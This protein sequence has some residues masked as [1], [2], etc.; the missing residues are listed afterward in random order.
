MAL[1][2][3]PILKLIF[4]A[5]DA[6]D[7]GAIQSYH[8]GDPVL[9]PKSELPALIGQADTVNVQDYTNA[10]DAHVMRYVLTLVTDIRDFFNDPDNDETTNIHYGYQ[11][12]QKIMEERDASTYALKATSIV[13]ILRSNAQLANNVQLDTENAM[14]ISYGFTQG[15]R[16]ENTW[17]WE[18]DISFNVFFTQER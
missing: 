12:A 11:I 5:I 13:D 3:D 8:Y 15:L 10:E 16:G 9:L 14:T 2:Q 4:D 6:N 17:A 18:A 7:G 1:Y